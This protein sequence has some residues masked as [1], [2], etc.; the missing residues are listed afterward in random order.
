MQEACGPRGP[1]ASDAPADPA[2][3]PHSHQDQSG[4]HHANPPARGQGPLAAPPRS[5]LFSAPFVFQTL[6]SEPQGFQSLPAGLWGA[7]QGRAGKGWMKARQVLLTEAATE[8]ES[9]LPCPGQWARAGDLTARRL[10]RTASPACGQLMTPAGQSLLCFPL[11]GCSG[12]GQC[13]SVTEWGLA[14]S[15]EDNEPFPSLSEAPRGDC[16]SFNPQ[17]A[18]GGKRSLDPV[19]WGD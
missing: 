10:L 1:R 6:P 15:Q 18:S 7:E 4:L 14:E 12:E 16:L 13:C 2:R 8:A 3:G 5:C 9:R 19:T 17:R 11:P